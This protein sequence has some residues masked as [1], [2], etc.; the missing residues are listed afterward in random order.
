MVISAKEIIN[1][2]YSNRVKGQWFASTPEL[3]KEILEKYKQVWEMAL[4]GGL[5]DW[6]K[7]PESCLALVIILD[8]FPLNMFR[9]TAKSFQ[10]ERKSVEIAEYAVK[11]NFE[12]QLDKNK[13]AFLFMPFMHSE[14]LKDQDLSISLF[15]ENNLQ[16]NIRFAE[17]HREII[18]KYGRFPH[19]NRILG[20]DS[21][22]DEIKYL[23]SKEAFKG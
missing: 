17:H 1:F 13:L 2:W 18:R 20:R 11:N 10:S 9:G 6:C 7:K 4:A 19:R 14:E 16:G 5:D 8:Q 21:T 12:Q 15:K 3:D 22:D 23:E